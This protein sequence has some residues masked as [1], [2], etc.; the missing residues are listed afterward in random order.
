MKIS[1]FTLAR[2]AVR[3]G[4]PLTESLR[5]LLPLVD[6]LIIA[7]GDSDDETE[8][9]VLG[10]EADYPKIRIVRTQWE[11]GPDVL[12]V[13]TNLALKE[14]TGDWGLYLQADEVLH[15]SELDTIRASI[16]RH[17]TRDTEGLL[18]R[19]HHFWRYYRLEVD[20]YTQFYP[21]AV[22][23]IRLGCGIESTGDAA[24]F[25]VRRGLSH[26]GLIKGYAGARVFHYRWCNPPSTQ[27]ARLMN[28]NQIYGWKPVSVDQAESFGE[29][30]LKRYP[31]SHPAVMASRISA[32]EEPK[33]WP[34]QSLWPA[35]CRAA[36]SAILKP[37]ATREWIRPVLP[38]ILT[39]ILWRLQKRRG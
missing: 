33:E 26:R 19:Y 39:N 23:A 13:Q 6:E 4:Y 34:A 30:A 24:G 15:E 35:L 11:Q 38:P 21:Y 1:G 37:R 5:S 17:H 29:I 16:E 25:G 20:D 18:F 14:C 2:N 10:L 8:D 36:G 7:L 32:T 9:V 3:L 12:A 31:G 27:A 28:V 22:R